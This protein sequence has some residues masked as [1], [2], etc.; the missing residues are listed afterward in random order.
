MSLHDELAEQRPS[1]CKICTYLDTLPFGE[2]DEW[3]RELSLPV[4]EIGNMSVVSALRR[5]GVLVEETSVRRH[6][7][8]H[9]VKAQH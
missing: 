2:A 3:E 1:A 9:L 6:R 8:N 7:R 5:R 4:S